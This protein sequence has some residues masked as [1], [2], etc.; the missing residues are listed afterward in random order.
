VFASDV[1]RVDGAHGDL[2]RVAGPSGSPLG[3]AFLSERSQIALRMLVRGETWPG[4]GIWAARVE[5][6][7][8]RRAGVV[9]PGGAFRAVFAESDGLP[10]LVVDVYGAHA[11][12][13]AQTL[14]S[15]R[16]LPRVLDALDERLEIASVLAR[17]DTASRTLEGLPREVVALRGAPPAAVAV[18]EG[19]IEY[20]ADLWR[21]QKTGAFLDQRT[22]RTR[23]GELARG[24]VLDVFSY[25][26]SFAL[27]AA[28]RAERVV[29]VDSSADALARA[30]ENAARN[31]FTRFEVRE[32]NAFEDL[33]GRAAAGERW[34]LVI[35]D[36]PAFAKGRSDAEAA[37]R[38]YKEINLRAM[39]LLAPAGVLVTCSCSYHMSE[40]EF[41]AMLA[42]AAADAGRTFRVAERRGASIDHPE[43]VGFPESRYLKCAVLVRE[44]SLE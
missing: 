29:A 38:G 13:Q 5:A 40:A 2:V 9:V 12:V 36:P 26:G 6:A 44:E 19:E 32:A 43:R 8:A 28:V 17:N 30:K 33:R 39:R 41:H 35:L 7:L 18:R 1:L 10:G 4:D 37:R 20:L 25:H 11:V 23:V 24:S 34:D 14:A 27:H 42:D 15:E 31:G 3:F 21:G 22:N 16:V